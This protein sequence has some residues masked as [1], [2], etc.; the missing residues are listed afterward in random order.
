MKKKS[1]PINLSNQIW[2]TLLRLE[3]KVDSIHTHVNINKEYLSTKEACSFLGVGRTRLWELVE[4][5]KI[6][7]LKDENDRNRYST[8]ELKEYLAKSFIS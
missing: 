6:T 5:S 8:A 1:P 2:E 7:K 3:K 4:E